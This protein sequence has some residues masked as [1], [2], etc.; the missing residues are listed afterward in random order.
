MNLRTIIFEFSIFLHLDSVKI[1]WSCELSEEQITDM[2]KSFVKM[3]PVLPPM[4]IM[5]NEDTVGSR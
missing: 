5:T 2:R 4:V 1:G 3:R